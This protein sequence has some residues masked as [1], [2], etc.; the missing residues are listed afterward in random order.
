MCMHVA[1]VV[2]V[3]VILMILVVVLVVVGVPTS[4][5]RGVCV[6]VMVS[7]GTD[8]GSLIKSQCDVSYMLKILFC[9][10]PFMHS[11]S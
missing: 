2:I 4:D 7:C 5:G 3:V 9:V 1:Q 11:V 6:H 8:P 10:A